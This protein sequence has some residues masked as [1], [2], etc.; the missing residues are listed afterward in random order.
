MTGQMAGGAGG[1]LP[2]IFANCRS[3]QKRPAA[4]AIFAIVTDSRYLHGYFD[5]ML[6]LLFPARARVRRPSED[7]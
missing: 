6:L 4:E 5:V 3:L 2:F 1:G 7:P